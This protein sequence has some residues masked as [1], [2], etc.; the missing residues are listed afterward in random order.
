MFKFPYRKSQQRND[1]APPRTLDLHEVHTFTI[2]Q[3]A[4]ADAAADD[5]GLLSSMYETWAKTAAMDRF[6]QNVL[7]KHIQCTL[8][9]SGNLVHVHLRL[10]V[11]QDADNDNTRDSE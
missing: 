9:H 8:C 1:T 4:A 7:K 6:I 11:L 5:T 2:P 10:R 3:H